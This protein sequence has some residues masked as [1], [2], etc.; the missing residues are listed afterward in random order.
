[1]EM[2]ERMAKAIWEAPGVSR[3]WVL[4][5]SSHKKACRT[6]ALRV[7]HAMREPSEKMSD[8]MK[9]IWAAMIDAAIKEAAES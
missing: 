7:L 6:T 4:L 8:E 5:H 3:W 9:P 2:I 1:M